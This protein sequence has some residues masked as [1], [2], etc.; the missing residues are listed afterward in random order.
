[1]STGAWCRTSWRSAARNARRR[2]P[3]AFSRSV[4]A[5]PAPCSL[6]GPVGGGADSRGRNG[7]APPPA[8]ARARCELGSPGGSHP[9]FPALR[10][11]V[12]SKAESAP[13]RQ[14]P[15][16][17]VHF[18]VTRVTS[19]RHRDGN[20]AEPGEG[21]DWSGSLCG[22]A[23]P[24]LYPTP[25]HCRNRVTRVT[26]FRQCRVQGR[27]CRAPP[28]RLPGGQGTGTAGACRSRADGWRRCGRSDSAEIFAK[29]RTDADVDRR[30]MTRQRGCP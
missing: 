27:T 17:R 15:R 23:G 10:R 26:S 28:D 25:G 5:P 12:A 6:P 20:A 11:S 14:T 9:R 16:C 30:E 7:L 22:R 18:D 8:P 24:V 21:G 13:G 29:K 2:R 4:P 19:K 1:M 3:R